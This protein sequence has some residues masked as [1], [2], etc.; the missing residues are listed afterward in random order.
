MGK[1]MLLEVPAEV[2]EAVRLPRP[3]MD[4]PISID[5]VPVGPV[6]LAG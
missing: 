1:N 3:E 6:G 4:Q 2:I 5:L